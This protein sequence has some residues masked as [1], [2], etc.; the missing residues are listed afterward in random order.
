MRIVQGWVGPFVAL[1]LAPAAAAQIMFGEP[2][3]ANPDAG[4]AYPGA[5]G[6]VNGDG[7]VDLAYTVP[8]LTK[9]RAH[10]CLGDGRGRFAPPLATAP[11]ISST[12][13][14]LG[15]LDGDGQPEL[16]VMPDDD[17]APLALQVWTGLGGNAFSGPASYPVAGVVPSS[18][19]AI[20][21]EDFDGD[22]DLDVLVRLTWPSLLFSEYDALTLLLN[23]GSG[24]LLPQVVTSGNGT[25][26]PAAEAGDLDGDGLADVVFTTVE[27]PTGSPPFTHTHAWL[28]QPGGGFVQSQEWSDAGLV[29]VVDLDRDAVPDVI[30]ETY[31]DPTSTFSLTVHRGLGDGT[32]AAQAPQVL[33]P[34][35]DPQSL[36]DFD[37]DGALDLLMTHFTGVIA[38][39]FAVWPGDGQGAFDASKVAYANRV[40]A[41]NEDPF[42]QFIAD[43]FADGRPDILEE[44]EVGQDGWIVSTIPN[45]TYPAGAPQLDLG[46][47]QFGGDG[48]PGTRVSG[49]FVPDDLVTVELWEVGEN[50]PAL[51]VAGLTE[52]LLPFKGG[53]MVPE[54]DGHFGPIS[55]GSAPILELEGRWPAGLPVGATITLQ[56]WIADPVAPQGMSASTAVRIA[57]P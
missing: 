8:E 53:V 51:L 38:G 22:A 45:W 49:S 17:P 25:G 31:D 12:L 56:W 5:L 52:S 14:A 33:P 40:G 34:L 21:A 43:A 35:A 4:H 47:P 39:T 11:E 37:G 9:L 36:A 23:D 27:E 41:M 54:P 24:V 28:G 1:G 42:F 3:V 57:Q 29:T 44:G 46:H 30:L 16:I 6:D 26:I 2:V 10:L 48:W 15:D 19:G 13:L 18:Y 55:T 50:L 32:F 20:T 7:L